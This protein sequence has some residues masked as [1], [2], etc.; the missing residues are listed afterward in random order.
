M[1]LYA[2]LYRDLH[3]FDLTVITQF[4]LSGYYC[5]LY[6]TFLECLSLEFPQNAVILLLANRVCWCSYFCETEACSKHEAKLFITFRNHF[7]VWYFEVKYQRI[8]IALV[9]TKVMQ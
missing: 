7:C 9:R 4:H 8:L 3:K 2:K 6:G 1:Y 5:T